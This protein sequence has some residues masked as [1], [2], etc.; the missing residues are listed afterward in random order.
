MKKNLMTLAAVLCCIVS[1]TVLTSCF[2]KVDNAVPQEPTMIDP[3]VDNYL[4][5]SDVNRN[6]HPGDSFYD[7]A[8]GSW[9]KNHDSYDV[10]WIDEGIDYIS[11]VSDN[12]LINNDDPQV[13][14]LISNLFGTPDDKKELEAIAKVLNVMFDEYGNF[15]ILRGWGILSDMGYA[16][17]VARYITPGNN[18]FYYVITAGVSSL[19]RDLREADKID[20]LRTIM[21]SCLLPFVKDVTQADEWAEKVMVL[22]DKAWAVNNPQLNGSVMERLQ[23][24]KRP[25]YS[26]AN[27]MNGRRAGSIGFTPERM[28]EYY[29]M[30]LSRDKVDAWSLP[31]FE[32]LEN[33]DPML[34]FMYTVYTVMMENYNFMCGYRK[35]DVAKNLNTIIYYIK[36]TVPALINI[37]DAEALAPVVNQQECL[38]D[39]ERLRVKMAQRIQNLDWM[40]DA[41][42]E[43]AQQKLQKMRFYAGVPENLVIKG[44]FNLTG[45]CFLEDMIQART[46]CNALINSYVGKPTYGYMPDYMLMNFPLSYFNAVYSSDFNSVYILPA[47]CSK[48]MYPQSDGAEDLLR[49]YATF[50][51]FAHELCHGFDSKGSQYDG[52][53]YKKDW[54]APSDKQQ[55]EV[56]KQQMVDRF[57]ELWAYEGQHANGVK[58]LG[59][60]M[61]DLGGVRLAFEMFKDVMAEQG[62]YGEH[63]KH[64][65]REFFMHY[66]QVWKEDDRGLDGYRSQYLYDV[67]SN[68]T[69]RINGIVRIMDEWY[70]L[71]MV[72]SGD[73]YVAPADRPRIW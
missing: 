21:R 56:K 43:A 71:F 17:P 60:N 34:L 38:A 59:E 25:Q 63:L 36:N 28:V 33:E 11:T 22:A 8:V 54:W 51:V 40:S 12:A 37:S 62:Y 47:F 65:L 19:E 27:A 73:I 7:F 23:G 41:T 42:K 50:Y 67:H 53:G 10:C 32:E 35:I 2:D 44:A 66:A 69:N 58:T 61:A 30:N 13:K 39:L 18:M 24:E 26:I 20:K 72:K 45:E 48:V 55:F 16:T 9:V 46:Q 52:E 70:D 29:G 14:H 15:D 31:F 68:S 5:N 4:K 64:Q 6:V 49:R 3:V 1:A 57:N